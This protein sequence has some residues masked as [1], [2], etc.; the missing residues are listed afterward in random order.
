MSVFRFSHKNYGKTKG[1]SH[2]SFKSWFELYGY[3]IDPLSIKPSTELVGRS[4][5]EKLLSHNLSSGNVV[6]LKGEQGIG[7]TS[8]LKLVESKIRE[9]DGFDA[10]YF[11]SLDDFKQLKTRISKTSLITSILEALG[12]EK[13]KK[14][15]VMVDEAHLL[16]SNQCNYLKKL[17][18]S[19]EIYSLALAL[20]EKGNLGIQSCFSH[21]TGENLNLKK[22]TKNDLKKILMKRFHGTNPLHDETIEY[23][24]RVSNGNPREFLLNC[25]KVVIKLHEFYSGEGAISLEEGKKALGEKTVRIEPTDEID[26]SIEENSALENLT[27]LQKSIINLLKESS[28]TLNELS[29]RTG[30][31][32]GTIGKQLSI[33][34]LRTKKDYME[35]KGIKKSLINKDK[36]NGYTIYSLNENA[37]Q[38]MD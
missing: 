34:C 20:S 9:S 8:L 31:S 12:L 29:K 32:V 35:R 5:E 33:L 13:R 10:Y 28:M 1:A 30:S 6:Q 19:D 15:V 2:I 37:G 11:S 7:K 14:K 23:F 3:G 21:R 38:I 17:Y 16:L 4:D 18:D 26:F 36:S 24:A 27:P 25:K 22:M